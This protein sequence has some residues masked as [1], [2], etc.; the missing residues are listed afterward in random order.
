[1]FFISNRMKKKV[2]LGGFINYINAQNINCRSIAV[3]LDKSK[4]DVRTLIL[5]NMSKT[6]LDGVSIYKV[7]QN[8]L[9]LFY[10]FLLGVLW[11][12]ISYL[13][14][15]QSTPRLVLFIAKIF[16]K[17]VFTTIEGN[18]CD[19]RRRSMINSFG[20]KKKMQKYFK[21]IP[22][23]YGITQHIVQNAVCGVKLNKMPLYL[24]VESD[25]FTNIKRSKLKNVVFIGSFI[26]RKKIDD[27]IN[28]AKIFPKLNFHIVGNRKYIKFKKQRVHIKNAWKNKYNSFDHTDEMPEN[29]LL[30]GKV[31][32]IQLSNLLK[33]FDLLFLPSRSEG[34]PKVI[35]EAAASSIPSIVYSDYGASEWITNGEN[36]FVVD[37]FSEVVDKIKYLIDN[38]DIYMKMSKGSELLANDFDW[39]NIIKQWEKVID[40][41]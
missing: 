40:N 29:I 26:R 37:D 41:L 22:N 20:S 5:S 33:N 25:N 32:R 39:K 12:D 7:S 2:F 38:P 16:G 13:P 15:H 21:N 36:G 1:M 24:G 28:L 3:Q 14:K 23:I 4:Y 9:S 6:H 27:Y 30:H 10:K 19:I 31:N 11:A 18:M 34:F 8:R 17:K 35:L